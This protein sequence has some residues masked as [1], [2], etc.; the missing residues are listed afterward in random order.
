MTENINVIE[1]PKGIKKNET[2]KAS[3]IQTKTLHWLKTDS[4]FK[5]S[6]RISLQIKTLEILGQN[7]IFLIQV[8]EISTC[9]MK[10]FTQ[11]G[12]PC[13]FVQSTAKCVSPPD[14][15]LLL[16]IEMYSTSGEMQ[17]LA[18]KISI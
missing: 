13:S 15:S 16:E 10:H 18:D 14:G 11:S 12:V 3:S 6:A 5:H 9:L 2:I 4:E 17:N 8:S 7:P 1:K